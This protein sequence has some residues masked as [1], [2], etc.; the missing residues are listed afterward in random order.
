MWSACKE[1]W[2]LNLTS[3]EQ[4]YGPV[5]HPHS[6]HHADDAIVFCESSGMRACNSRGESLDN[7]RGYARGLVIADGHVCVG[8]SCGRRRSKSTN[9]VTANAAAVFQENCGIEVHRRT[10][11][12][13]SDCEL[14]RYIDLY[15]YGDEIYDLLQIG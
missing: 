1:G 12:Q 3:G 15:P 6:A 5:H 9:Q 13:L 8:V 11:A 4:V 10:G 7:I 14:E 2:V